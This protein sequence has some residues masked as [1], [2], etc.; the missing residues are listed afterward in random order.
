M[1]QH[2][3]VKNLENKTAAWERALGVMQTLRKDCPWDAKQN[4]ESIR[5]NSIEEMY[6]LAEA[7]V[8]G[9]PK[10]IKKE[11][12]DVMEQLMFYAMFAEEKGEFDMADILNSMCDKLVFRHPHVFNPDGSLISQVGVRGGET[13]GSADDVSKLWEQVKQK[14]KDGNKTILSGIPASLPSL[15]KAYRMQDKARNAGFDWAQKEDVWPKV[16]EEIAEFEAEVGNMDPEKMEAEFGDLLFSLINAARLYTIK[17]DN[18]LEKTNQKFQRR[19]TYVETEARKQG[20][21]LNDMTL[22]E[23]DALWDE[24]KAKGL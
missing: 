14:E 18:A 7:L 2:L 16:R 15:I 23:M 6:E 19:F 11:C 5:Q 24:A 10:E 17:P 12:G 3:P 4:N 13:V 20:K 1:E 21:M 8:S 22:A 9:D